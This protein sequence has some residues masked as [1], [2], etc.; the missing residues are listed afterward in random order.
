MTKTHSLDL[1]EKVMAH[2]KERKEKTQVATIC[3]LDR[4]TIDIWEKRE[5]NGT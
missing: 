2:F 1:R 3:R 4:K 5:K